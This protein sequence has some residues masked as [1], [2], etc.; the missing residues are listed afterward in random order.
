MMNKIISKR[1]KKPQSLIYAP[2]ASAIRDNEPV[3]DLRQ[4]KSISFC[5]P[6]CSAL[7]SLLASRSFCSS[8]HS[9]C[10]C[11]HSSCFC[12]LLACLSSHSATCS[13]I[14]F[15]H[16]FVNNSINSEESVFLE[17]FLVPPFLFDGS[18]VSTVT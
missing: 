8:C 3:T 9:S 4:S 11:F 2:A 6:C 15:S 1:I 17:R 5:L 18:A 10:C 13:S 16:L 7:A 12:F 14:S